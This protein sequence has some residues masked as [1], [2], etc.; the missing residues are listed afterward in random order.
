MK[1]LSVQ[2]ISV[3]E[4]D[5]VTYSLRTPTVYDS[6]RLRRLARA[7]GA[8]VVPRAELAAKLRAG[9]ALI[10]ADDPAE[11]ERWTA[12]LDD[13]EL[14]LAE[15]RTHLLPG[16]HPEPASAEAT[17]QA[18]QRLGLLAAQMGELEDVVARHCPPYAGALADAGYWAEMLELAAIRLLVIATPSAGEAEAIQSG[19]PRRF[20]P[21]NDGLTDAQLAAIPRAHRPTLAMHALARFAPTESERK[22]SL[23]PPA[24][25]STAAPSTSMADPAS[26]AANG[27]APTL[28]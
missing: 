27:S 26:P 13:Y 12:I 22:N 10:C 9:L 2:D 17:A 24:G 14:L 28:P 6:A 4:I 23:S 18:A 16:E 7:A 1:L 8:R 15:V 20:A 3:I 19:L 11:H 5:G 25:P 21:R